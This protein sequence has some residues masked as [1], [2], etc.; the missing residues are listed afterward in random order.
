MNADER[1]VQPAEWTRHEACWLAWP[2]HEDLWL[3]NLAPAR[4]AFV[5]LA[6]AIGKQPGGE[7]LDVLV[8]DA[9]QEALASRALAAVAPR[10]HRVPFGDIWLRD[11]APIFVKNA[12]GAI[13]TARF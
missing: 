8:P 7:R 13:A 3:E 6:E 12:R 2:R 4:E 9:E 10:F 11:T 1:F 5:A